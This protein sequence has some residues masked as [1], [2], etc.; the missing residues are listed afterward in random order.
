M[1]S[2]FRIKRLFVE[3]GHLMQELYTYCVVLKQKSSSNVTTQNAC[4]SS[5]L[6]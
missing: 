5:K 2:L 1:L 3:I 4:L 6:L